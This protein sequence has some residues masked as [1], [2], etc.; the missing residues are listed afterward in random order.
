MEHPVV[1][2]ASV[3]GSLELEAVLVQ[4]SQ[5]LW[6]PVVGLILLIAGYV[7]VQLGSFLVEAAMRRFGAQRRVLV[8]AEG[9]DTIE[10][11][12]LS[13][14]KELEGLRLCSRVSPMLGLIATMVPLGPALATVSGG[15]E[16][17]ALMRLG[18]S[19]ASVILA[20]MSASIAFTIHT[21][22]RRWLIEELSARLGDNDGA[23]RA[24]D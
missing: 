3:G 11:L 23:E 24:D 20:L 15:A 18:D 1:P 21:V 12:E 8:A 10:A 6:W 4:L 22:R 14:V 9:P 19:F 17:E 16:E 5:W 2:V 7:L 13:M